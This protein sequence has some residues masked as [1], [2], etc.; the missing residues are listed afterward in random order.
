MSFEKIDTGIS[1]TLKDYERFKILHKFLRKF[2][3]NL[4]ICWVITSGREYKELKSKIKDDSYYVISE[5]NLIPEL[6][7]YRFIQGILYKNTFL[8]KYFFNI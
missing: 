7:I 2:F 5:A 8:R 1:L 6:K 3:K 4:N